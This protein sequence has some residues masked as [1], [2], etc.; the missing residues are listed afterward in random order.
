MP[1]EFD[2]CMDDCSAAAIA[3]SECASSTNGP[4]SASGRC[5]SSPPVTINLRVEATTLTIFEGQITI[6]A[7][8]MTPNQ[9]GTHECDGP[10]GQSP[11]GTMLTGLDDAARLDRF[12]W[13]G[14]FLDQF[15]DFN[16]GEWHHRRLLAA[17]LLELRS[18]K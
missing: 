10:S 12:T 9:G 4:F 18:C 16:I 6:T 7:H 5:G 3:M 15:N 11:G 8:E 14:R 13:D 2:I 1:G 17:T